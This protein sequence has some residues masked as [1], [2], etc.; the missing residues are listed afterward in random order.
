VEYPEEIPQLREQGADVVFHVY[1]E[2]GLG[3]ADSA[4]EVAGLRR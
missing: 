1:E 4:A 3:L 2:A